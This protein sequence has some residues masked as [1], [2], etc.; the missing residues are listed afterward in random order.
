MIFFAVI[1]RRFPS[2]TSWLI[3]VVRTFTIA[4]SLA[5]KNA[6]SAIKAANAANRMA[7]S[8]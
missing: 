4:N 3:R 6:V 7:M 1:A 5:T 2:A 8:K